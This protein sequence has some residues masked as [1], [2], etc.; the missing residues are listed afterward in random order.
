[1]LFSCVEVRPVCTPTMHKASPKFTCV[2][3][4]RQ[5]SLQVNMQTGI[6]IQTN[7]LVEPTCVYQS[8]D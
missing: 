8:S 6:K 2:V 3:T 1:M 7:I 5:L 4:F